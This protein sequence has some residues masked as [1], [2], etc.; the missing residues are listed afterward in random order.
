MLIFYSKLSR[1]ISM[2]F[3]I[4][5]VLA[6]LAAPVVFALPVASQ[7]V[8]NSLPT[9]AEP[10]QYATDPKVGRLY[11][12]GLP[13][14]R[15]AIFQTNDKTD[16]FELCATDY[17]ETSA[18][19]NIDDAVEK[20]SFIDNDTWKVSASLEVEFARL[21]DLMGVAPEVTGNLYFEVTAINIE[22][23]RLLEDSEKFIANSLGTKCKNLI[24]S[25]RDRGG[26]IA[27]VVESF[28][29]EELEVKLVVDG[30][31]SSSPFATAQAKVVKTRRFSNAVIAV[32]FVFDL[33]SD[34]Q[35]L[36]LAQND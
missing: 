19:K 12:S 23:R 24:Q 30:K 25:Y 14:R 32:D 5:K 28:R 8:S 35:D 31:V 27:L 22:R 11:F 3:G 36:R 15:S 16:F 10:I 13:A 20:R 6:T 29:A 2:S 17:R 18:L 26:S 34:H 33:L 9:G 7:S 4:I 21:L 1:V